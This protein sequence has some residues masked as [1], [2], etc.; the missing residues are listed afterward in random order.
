[1][2]VFVDITIEILDL[3]RLYLLYSLAVNKVG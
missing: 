3:A 1:L 2:D